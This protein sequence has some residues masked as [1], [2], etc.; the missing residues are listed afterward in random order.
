MASRSEC[1]C[2][3]ASLCVSECVHLKGR[4]H[5]EFLELSL[6]LSQCPKFACFS[7]LG[8]NLHFGPQRKWGGGCS[9]C[10][11]ANALLSFLNSRL[12]RGDSG[13]KGW[14]WGIE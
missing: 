2:A 8:R 4:G 6:P 12:S 7:Y 9:F 13:E 11:L 14:G 5:P 3:T 10:L 1:E